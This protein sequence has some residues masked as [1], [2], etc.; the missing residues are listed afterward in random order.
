MDD[1]EKPLPILHKETQPFWDAA[2]KHEVL[3]PRCRECA[4]FFF[5]PRSTCP[6]CLSDQIDWVAASGKGTIYSFTVSYRPG[7][8]AFI[9]DVPYNI[10]VVELEEGVRMMTN[11]L[12]CKNEELK[13]GM[14]VE[15]VFEDINQQVTLIKFKPRT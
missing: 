3:L 14:S 7:H 5:Y 12:R 6:Y 9:S 13:I 2:K 10:A 8:P 1:Y 15:A 4:K 11:I